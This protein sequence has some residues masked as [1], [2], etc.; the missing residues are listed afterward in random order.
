MVIFRVIV[1]SVIIC[2]IVYEATKFGGKIRPEA[3]QI[4]FKI[5][6]WKVIYFGYDSIATLVPQITD[7]H[8]TTLTGWIISISLKIVL[9]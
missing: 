8:K 9:G 3:A 5:Q 6:L 4:F 1:N 7:K 2:T